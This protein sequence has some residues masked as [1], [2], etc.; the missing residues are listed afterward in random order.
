MSRKKTVLFLCT[1]N[2]CR[3]QMAEGFARHYWGDRYTVLSAGIEKHG[4]NE[5]AV[6]AMR[7]SGIDI[8]DHQSKTLDEVQ[9]RPDVVVTVCGHAD[10]TC[11]VLTGPIRKLHVGFNDPPTMALDASSDAEAM[12]H[13]REVRDEIEAFIKELPSQLTPVAALH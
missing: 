13:Y 11:P 6:Q 4:L 8:S 9:G 12:V 5:R 1:G 10:Q 3:S 2:S 7:D